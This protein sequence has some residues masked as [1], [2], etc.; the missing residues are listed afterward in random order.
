VTSNFVLDCGPCS[1]VTVSFA[2]PVVR[3]GW[4]IVTNNNDDVTL[5]LF[6]GA[7][8]LGSLTYVTDQ[9][10]V[11]IGIEDLGGFDSVLI[12]S[13]GTGNQ[14]FVADLFRFDA[15]AATDEVPEPATLALLGA[16]LL[17]L[18]ATRRRAQV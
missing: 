9:T 11:F 4:V 3:F 18:G 17:G 12:D 14:V 7:A 6:N 16:G 13:N 5:T 10:A 2:A 1:N 15:L 8:N